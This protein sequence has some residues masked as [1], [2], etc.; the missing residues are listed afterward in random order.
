MRAGNKHYQSGRDIPGIVPVFPL[1]GALL[2]PGGNMPLNIFE[3]RYLAMTDYALKSDRLIGMIQPDA[4]GKAGEHGP[5]LYRVG[6]LGR[7]TGVQE[8]G[9]GRYMINLCGVCRFEIIEELAPLS[10][11]RMVS[12]KPNE[13]DLDPVAGNGHNLMETD[14]NLLIA[15]FRKY[16]KANDMDTDWSAVERTDDETLVT[17]LCMMSPYGPAE[18]QALLEACNLK[19]RAETLVAITEM[20][21]ANSNDDSASRLQ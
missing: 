3:T 9:D 6:C 21:L 15:T 1:S 4:A 5:S 8:T 19:T 10:G 12:I 14:R 11:F 17:A 2:L 7:L 16:L 18:K 20:A 13:A